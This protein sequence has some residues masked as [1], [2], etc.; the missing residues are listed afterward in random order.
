MHGVDW[1]REASI[2]AVSR[3]MRL[4]WNA[5]DCIIQ[6]AVRRGLTRCPPAPSKHLGV[7]EV[8]F[9]GQH[10]YITLVGKSR[11]CAKTPTSS[12]PGVC[13][14][15]ASIPRRTKAW[16]SSATMR[17]DVGSGLIEWRSF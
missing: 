11:E 9:S 6:R 4:S 16:S 15:W 12:S 7:D 2:Q 8:S 17:M 3:R 13:A 1:L 5:I 10:E 14:R